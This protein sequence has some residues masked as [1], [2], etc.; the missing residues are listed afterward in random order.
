[1]SPLL[2]KLFLSPQIFLNFFG[3]IILDNLEYSEEEK[4]KKLE[5][6]VHAHVLVLVSL[7]L[8]VC[9]LQELEKPKQKQVPRHLQI[10]KQYVLLCVSFAVLTS[11]VCYHSNRP[12]RVRPPAGI[13]NSNLE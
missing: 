8:L 1:M 10:F 9:C 7:R 5:V 2:L 12:K 13:E 11:G 6:C 3:A 4:K